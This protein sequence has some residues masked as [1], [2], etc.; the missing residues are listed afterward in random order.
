MPWPGL[1]STHCLVL[2]FLIAFPRT[3]LC[4]LVDKAFYCAQG[5]EAGRPGGQGPCASWL[6]HPQ[7]QGG[8][9]HIVGAY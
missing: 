2:L 4:L 9:R 1:I 8:N 6:F 7:L 5:S 3:Q